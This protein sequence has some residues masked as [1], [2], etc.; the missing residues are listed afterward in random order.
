MRLFSQLIRQIPNLFTLMNLLA[1]FT[2]IHFAFREMYYESVICLG[3]ALHMDLFD[4]LA[5]RMLKAVSELGKQLDS[6]SDLV[7]FGVLP[8]LLSWIFLSTSMEN[9]AALIPSL[10]FVLA[11]CVRLGIFNLKPV[12]SDFS[13][14]PV[15][16]AAMLTGSYVLMLVM[17]VN[18]PLFSNPM[19]LWVLTLISAILMLL[20]VRM[21]SMKFKH[22]K[23]KGNA[24]RYLL[25]MGG[26]LLLVIFAGK[27]GIFYSVIWYLLLSFLYAISYKSN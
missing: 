25:A 17:E 7:S 12:S 5:A 3:I 13:G 27:G 14:L 26:I 21:L 11:A 2:G 4:G 6:L 15:P 9:L 20:P 1:G 16:G 18:I 8:A 24:F 10:F 22:L 19:I 23:W